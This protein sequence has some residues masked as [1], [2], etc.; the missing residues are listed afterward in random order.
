MY[1]GCK[2]EHVAILSGRMERGT[3]VSAHI[4]E[5]DRKYIYRICCEAGH[6]SGYPIT[7]PLQLNIVVGNR[8]H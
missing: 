7:L 6:F 4:I 5:W 8:S 2:P 3:C 1:S